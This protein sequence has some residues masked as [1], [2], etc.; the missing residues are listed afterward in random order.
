[1]PNETQHP[2]WELLHLRDELMAGEF[3]E[4][5]A[6][7]NINIS[8]QTLANYA[9]RGWVKRERVGVGRI[10]RGQTAWYQRRMVIPFLYV[11]ELRAR[12]DGRLTVDDIE[13]KLSEAKE[14]REQH[15]D[16]FLKTFG[17]EGDWDFYLFA[18]ISDLLGNATPTGSGALSARSIAHFDAARAHTL[19]GGS[20]ALLSQLGVPVN[21]PSTRQAILDMLRRPADAPLPWAGEPWAEAYEAMATDAP[22]G[23]AA[24]EQARYD[25]LLLMVGVAPSVATTVVAN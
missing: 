21:G 18:L 16:Y 3:L 8:E 6:E 13:E 2:Y 17:D 1:M 22:I 20:L 14:A 19:R 9:K 11:D 25:A 10:G 5:L 4:A 7:L 24:E 23:T 15:R 12:A